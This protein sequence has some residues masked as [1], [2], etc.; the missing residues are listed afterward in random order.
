M[1]KS[2]LI[3]K[4][5]GAKE[6]T[7]V[8]SIDLVLAALGMLEDEAPKAT[9]LSR[10]LID[11]LSKRIE[12]C[13]DHN[14]DDLV[15]KENITFDINYGNVI[16]VDEACIDVYETMDHI[17]AILEEFESEPE[18]DSAGFSIADAYNNSSF[19]DPFRNDITYRFEDEESHH[20]DDP[21]CNCSI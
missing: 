12:R 6:L 17:N 18:I 8:V 16:E 21:G 5:E 4:L 15:D 1:K 10:E 7:S 2:E 13:L 3:A 9:T 14:C 19:N 20:C 11:E